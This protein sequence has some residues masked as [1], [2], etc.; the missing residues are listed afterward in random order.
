MRAR[1]I[2]GWNLRRIRVERGLSLEELAGDSEVDSSTVAR[3]ER[4]TVNASIDILER[5]AKALRVSVGALL[6]EPQPGATA[7]KPLRA[8]RRARR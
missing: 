4:S 5:L 8:G 3:I 2:V 1:R 6:V 7:P